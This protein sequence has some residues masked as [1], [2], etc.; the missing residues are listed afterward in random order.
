MKVSSECV[1]NEVIFFKHSD[2]GS[3]RGLKIALFHCMEKS[4]LEFLNPESYS[5]IIKVEKRYDFLPRRRRID[6][7][8]PDVAG[9]EKTWL[10]IRVEVA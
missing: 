5:I 8:F 1:C 4:K 6:L 2:F 3:F 10:T 7:G 9:D